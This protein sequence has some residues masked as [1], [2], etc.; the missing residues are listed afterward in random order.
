MGQLARD[1]WLL[2]DHLHIERCAIIGFSM[3]GAVAVEMAVQSPS[4]CAR[5]M[6]INAQPS[7]KVDTWRKWLEVYSQIALIHVLGLRLSS[8]VMARRLFPH[9]HQRPMRDRVEA[10]V[11]SYGRG[12][13]MA[14]VG[15]LR[16]WCAADR[17]PTLTCPVCMLVGEFDYTTVDEKKRWARL[18]GA[19]VLVVEGSRHGTPFDAVTATNGV[20]VAFVRNQ[21]FDG[22]QELRAD[23]PEQAPREAPALPEGWT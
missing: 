16:G 6:L 9:P 22:P 20:L 8:R 10:V 19:D 21:P 14:M 17:L 23:T 3:G 4:R 7:Y 1:L 2:C 5:L 12:R 18:M 11:G 13:Y 15:A